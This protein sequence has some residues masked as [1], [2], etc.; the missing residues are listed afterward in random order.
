MVNEPNM[1]KVN[2]TKSDNPTCQGSF[3]LLGVVDY[4][5]YLLTPLRSPSFITHDKSFGCTW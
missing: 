3:E 1:S 4:P 5:V 2:L